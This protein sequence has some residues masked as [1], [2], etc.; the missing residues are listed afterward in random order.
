MTNLYTYQDSNIRRTWILF[1][2]FFIVVI[3]LGWVFSNAYGDYSILAFAIIFSVVYSLISYWS[4]ASIALSMAHAH[5]IQKSD[6]PMLWNIVENLCIASGLPM[7]K[8]YITPEMQINAFATGRNKEHAAVAVTQGALQRLNKVELEGVLAHELSH[9]GNR[10]ILVST[11]AAILAGIISLIA[12]IFL[13]SLFLGFGGGNRGRN[14]EGNEIFFIVAILLSILAPIGTM[15][16]QL[17]I[18]RRREA[19]ADA[20]GALLTR[21]PDG[22]IS[23]LRK[24]EVDTVPMASAKDS[25]A[26]MWLD[27]PFKGKGSSW[28]HKLFMT[29][30]PIEERIAALEQLSVPGQS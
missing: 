6:N 13:R 16:I 11:V 9:V 28:W 18:S 19:L 21:Y 7:P 3:G 15:L 2:V 8:L 17:A 20:D 22:L 4:S 27:N 1:I 14:S 30:P 29:H 5:E 25:T 10:D 23:A 24:I 26:H 12:D